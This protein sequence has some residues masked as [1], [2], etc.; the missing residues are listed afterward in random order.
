MNSLTVENLYEAIIDEIVDYSI[1]KGNTEMKNMQKAK[2]Y[3]KLNL[4][5]FV[6]ENAK[7]DN[8]FKTYQKDFTN[9]LSNVKYQMEEI[10]VFTDIS[11]DDCFLAYGLLC[12]LLCMFQE[13]KEIIFQSFNIEKFPRVLN[14]INEYTSIEKLKNIYNIKFEN[15]CLEYINNNTDNQF[16]KWFKVLYE[17][18]LSSIPIIERKKKNKKKKKKSKSNVDRNKN[19]DNQSIN[20][21]INIKDKNRI[22]NNLKEEEKLQHKDNEIESISAEEKTEDTKS[23]N[24]KKVDITFPLEIKSQNVNKNDIFLEEDNMQKMEMKNEILIIKEGNKQDNTSENNSIS[25]Q[26]RQNIKED[27][28][29]ID[30]LLEQFGNNQSTFSNNEKEM[31]NLLIEINKELKAT[32]KNLSGR[33]DLLEKHQVLLYNQI[34]K[35]FINKIE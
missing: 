34:E 32:K 5:I 18:D 8:V 11:D 16:Q 33:I 19:E 30:K 6:V 35:R 10:K 29:K 31:F 22:N 14:V 21:S 9:F 23:S 13:E 17:K 3:S 20:D 27:N 28:N 1:K 26:N 4:S 12:G 24:G 15:F 2:K 7:I 25:G